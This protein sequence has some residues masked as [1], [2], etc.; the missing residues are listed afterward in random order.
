MTCSYRILAEAQRELDSIVAYLLD[1]SDG[2]AAAKGFLDE[3]DE[4]LGLA[5]ETP[6]LFGLSRMPELAALGYRALFVRNYVVLYFYRDDCVY[7]AHVFHQR[8]DYA[9]LV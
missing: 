4:K 7:V 5:R 3:L 9:R 6:L 1:V 8:Q 2:P